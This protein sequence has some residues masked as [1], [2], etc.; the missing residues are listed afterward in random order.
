MSPVIMTD[1][2]L[3]DGRSDSRYHLPGLQRLINSE[4]IDRWILPPAKGGLPHNLRINCS[5][6]AKAKSQ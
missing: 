1:R 4:E 3:S 6:T 5:V 2:Y